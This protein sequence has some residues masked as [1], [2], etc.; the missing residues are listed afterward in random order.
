MS[1]LDGAVINDIIFVSESY[2][3]CDITWPLIVTSL[4]SEIPLVN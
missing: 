3:Y 1:P 2:E 4:V